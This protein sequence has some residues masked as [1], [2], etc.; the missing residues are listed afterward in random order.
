MNMLNVLRF[1]VLALA[2]AFV[3]S[4]V[5]ADVGSLLDLDY[6]RWPVKE[7]ASICSAFMVAR[8][9]W[10]SIPPVNVVLPRNTKD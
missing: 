10:W 3:S 6:V 7:T 9:C 1:P 8:C 2:L 5:L 4:G